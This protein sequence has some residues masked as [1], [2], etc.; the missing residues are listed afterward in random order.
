MWICLEFKTY[1]DISTLIISWNQCGYVLF[2]PH[3]SALLHLFFFHFV[4]L[5]YKNFSIINN[6][7]LFFFCSWIGVQLWCA[8]AALGRVH[9]KL[10]H[11]HKKICPQW[12]A[13]RAACCTQTPQQVRWICLHLQT[14]IFFCTQLNLVPG[15]C[16][17]IS[18]LSWLKICIFVHLPKIWNGSGESF[19]W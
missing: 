4:Y 1:V 6:K 19:S 13:V 5:Y 18:R 14:D 9:G 8:P 15:K 7:F 17:V 10:L 12:R 3:Q 16:C 11:G 2:I